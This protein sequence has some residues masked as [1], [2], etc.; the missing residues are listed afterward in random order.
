MQLAKGD[1]KGNI[2]QLLQMTGEE[3]R[4]TLSLVD[5]ICENENRLYMKYNTKEVNSTFKINSLKLA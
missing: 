4:Y 1:I 3:C 2:A 5:R